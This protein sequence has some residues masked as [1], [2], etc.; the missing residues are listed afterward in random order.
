MVGQ[1]FEEFE[2]LS[3]E[4]EVGEEQSQFDQ[5]VFDHKLVEKLIGQQEVEEG[6]DFEYK[7]VVK[8]DEAIAEPKMLT[9]VVQD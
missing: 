9:Q 3:V 6:K 8:E 4:E 1:A 5:E 2:K 7:F